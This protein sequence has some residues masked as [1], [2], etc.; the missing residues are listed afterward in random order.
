M[1][2]KTYINLIDKLTNVR[3]V[4]QADGLITEAFPK[5]LHT[6]LVGRI[7]S[8]H[9]VIVAG[10]YDGYIGTSIEYNSDDRQL[11][12]LLITGHGGMDDDNIEKAEVQAIKL[13]DELVELFKYYEKEG[14]GVIARVFN[15]YYSKYPIQDM[16]G[17]FWDWLIGEG[18]VDIKIDGAAKPRKM[19]Y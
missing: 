17:N 1:N 19:S 2:P 10:G 11:G 9:A 5:T 18:Y 7:D 4:T 12:I 13:A 3:P 8:D 15:A 6:P 14:E 16:M